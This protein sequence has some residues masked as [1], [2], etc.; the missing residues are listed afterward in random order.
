MS[1][2]V[3]LIVIP[4]RA[5]AVA[6]TLKQTHG[7]YASYWNAAHRSSVHAWQGRYYSCL[8]DSPHLWAALRYAERNPVRAGMV[9]E[10]EEWLWSSAAAHCGQAAPDPCLDMEMFRARWDV[11][12]WREYL[13]AGES[14][15]EIAALRQCTHTGRPLGTPEF[16]KHAEARDQG[17]GFKTRIAARTWSESW[18]L[19]QP[20]K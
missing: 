3:H 2:H 14:E 4:H 1:N 7:R 16:I 18:P 13:H 12:A 11:E 17:Q 9:A 10:P 6:L 8:L 5:D 20:T 19:E 15:S